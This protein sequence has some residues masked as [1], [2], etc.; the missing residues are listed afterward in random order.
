[1]SDPDNLLI[2]SFN[3]IAKEAR[4]S[5]N[6]SLQFQVFTEKEKWTQNFVLRFGAAVGQVEE[7]PS[8]F[9]SWVY[10]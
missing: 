4:V 7:E 9:V 2:V 10:V 5:Q 3:V 8:S 6:V 1:M